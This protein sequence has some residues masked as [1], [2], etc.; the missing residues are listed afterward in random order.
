MIPRFSLLIIFFKYSVIFANAQENQPCTIANID[1][2]DGLYNNFFTC[3]LQ[4]DYGCGWGT[5]DGLNR[6]DG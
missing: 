3:L 5:Y 4:N 1:F 2:K 6:Y